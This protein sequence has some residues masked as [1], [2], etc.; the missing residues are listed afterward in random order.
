MPLVTF[1]GTG[2]ETLDGSG[3]GTKKVIQ[4]FLSLSGML[5]FNIHLWMGYIQKAFL[6]PHLGTS[7]SRTDCAIKCTLDKDCHVFMISR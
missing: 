5:F 3:D 4:F 1:M 2:M 6:I 7:K